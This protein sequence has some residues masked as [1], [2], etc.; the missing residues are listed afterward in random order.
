MDVKPEN[1]ILE[2]HLP[3]GQIGQIKLID[4]GSAQVIA[5]HFHR[6][7]STNPLN[8]GG[9]GSSS[10]EFLAPEV[11]SGGP[12]APYTDMWSVGVIL[13]VCLR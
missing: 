5:N 2:Q 8:S 3:S 9:G 10:L 7:A 13:Y 6:P 11:I 4:F 1:L 12:V